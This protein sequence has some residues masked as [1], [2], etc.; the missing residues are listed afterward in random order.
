MH[1][2]L[3]SFSRDKRE[4]ETT[5]AMLNSKGRLNAF[6]LSLFEKLNEQ[7]LTGHSM[8]A[9][10]A[11]YENKKGI[12]QSLTESCSDTKTAENAFDVLAKGELFLDSLF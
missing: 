2:L 12:I 5:E 11:F 8:K 7:F 9:Y 3:Q 1:K 6:H 10:I 4:K